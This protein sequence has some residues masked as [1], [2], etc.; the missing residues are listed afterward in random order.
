MH[1]ESSHGEINCG[2][3]TSDREEEISEKHRIYLRKSKVYAGFTWAANSTFQAIHSKNNESFVLVDTLNKQ[4]REN[5]SVIVILKVAILSSYKEFDNLHHYTH[6]SGI[7]VGHMT[8]NN[9]DRLHVEQIN[10][11]IIL[12]VYRF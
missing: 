1:D 10:N 8:S 7:Y 4:Q 11:Q 9:S 3:F 5:G 6:F 12:D 2:R